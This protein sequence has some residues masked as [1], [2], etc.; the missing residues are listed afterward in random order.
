ME[1]A[2][3]SNPVAQPTR[4][5]RKV[6]LALALSFAAIVGC[7]D[8]SGP[9]PQPEVTPVD[10]ATAAKVTARVTYGGAIPEPIAINMRAVGACAQLHSEPVFEQPVQVTDGK[11]ANVVVYIKSGLENRAFRYP[12]TPVVIDQRGCLYHPRVVALMVGQALQFT[13]SDPEPHN[14]RGRPAEVDAWN[15]MMSRQGAQ[16]TLYFDKP[17]IGIRV[18]CDV[19]PW[20]S[21]W[22]SVLPHPYFGITGPDGQVVIENVPPGEYV[23]GAWH[24][25]LGTR[26]QPVTL[27]ASGEATVELSY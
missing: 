11:L 6:S 20:M 8:S 25:T 22:V 17:E 12:E 16:R 4:R 3:Y 18:G 15:F 1:V 14:V 21:A 24:E 2:V 5:P 27:A 23:I 9:P 26:E 10:T 7:S 19:H 13:N